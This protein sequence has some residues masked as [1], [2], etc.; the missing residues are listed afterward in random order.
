MRAEVLGAL[1]IVDHFFAQL[2][3]GDSCSH[4]QNRLHWVRD[5]N[6][7]E[8]RC[9]ARTKSGARALASLRNL[10]LGPTG[11]AGETNIAEGLRTLAR[12]PGLALSLV[13]C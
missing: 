3:S 4:S 7:D 6:F 2:L 8:D 11:L 5:W 1:P 10:A 12:D 9:Q 13:G